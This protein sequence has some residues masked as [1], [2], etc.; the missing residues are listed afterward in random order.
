MFYKTANIYLSILNLTNTLT[1][2]GILLLTRQ[3]FTIRANSSS[4]PEAVAGRGLEFS[5]SILEIA[6]KASGR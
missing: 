6:P 1:C 3:P 5:S 4:S 2:S